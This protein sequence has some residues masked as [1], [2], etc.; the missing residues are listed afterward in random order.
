[1][2]QTLIQIGCDFYRLELEKSITSPKELVTILKK[3]N[4][5]L[6]KEDLK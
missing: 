5:R 6:L 1:M 4:V 2:K 3:Y